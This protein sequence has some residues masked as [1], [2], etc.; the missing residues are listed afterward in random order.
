MIGGSL[1][2]GW[3][4][5]ACR[6]VEYEAKAANLRQVAFVR[7]TLCIELLQ[8]AA[9]AEAYL[10]NGFQSRATSMNSASETTSTCG[11]WVVN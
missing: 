9:L 8:E 11:T 5:G 3:F 7:Y 10:V 1:R 6:S 4:G 2:T